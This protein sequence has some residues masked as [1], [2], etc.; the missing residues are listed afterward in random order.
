MTTNIKRRLRITNIVERLPSMPVKTETPIPR[1]GV[2][3][4]GDPLGLYR[5]RKK[6]AWFYYICASVPPW[7]WVDPRN[8]G[9][10][11]LSRAAQQPLACAQGPYC[12]D[13]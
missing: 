13:S 10:T 5:H 3:I 2:R 7:H 12:P 9:S 4:S 11:H 1:G 8:P 6:K